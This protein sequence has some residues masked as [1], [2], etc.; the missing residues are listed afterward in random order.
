MAPTIP[1]LDQAAWL[2]LDFEEQM[3]RFY[4]SAMQLLACSETALRIGG[5]FA[6]YIMY[7][8][9]PAQYR[10]PIRVTPRGWQNLLELCRLA[11][12]S[13]PGDLLTSADEAAATAGASAD[14]SGQ[15]SACTWASGVR[16]AIRELLD[17]DALSLS[18]APFLLSNAGRND[19]P[20]AL[21][22]AR[23][24]GLRRSR[25]ALPLL[26]ASRRGPPAH[27]QQLHR[28]DRVRRRR[29]R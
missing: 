1:E 25:L 23:T 15:P 19:D 20:A 28:R 21:T 17:A 22:L 3:Q 12:V 4:M 11:E 18:A 24:L 6:L 29:G 13:R 16:S 8:C 2:S 7:Y 5:L 10:V 27:A 14:L 26:P 9:W